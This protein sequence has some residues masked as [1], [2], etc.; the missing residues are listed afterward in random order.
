MKKHGVSLVEILVAISILLAAMVP[1]WGLIGSSNQQ[2]MRSADEV[3]ASQ[4]AVE[5]ME[6]L[7]NSCCPQC[8]P[9]DDAM[10]EYNLSSGGVVTIGEEPPVTVKISTFEEYL[11]PKLYVTASTVA[12]GFTGTRVI[13]RIVALTIQYRSKEGKDLE[14]VLRGFVSASR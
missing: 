1:L 5:I 14:Y 6:Q 10:Q 11:M 9:A 12:D 8:L 7:E 2:V 4:L 13:G 3:K